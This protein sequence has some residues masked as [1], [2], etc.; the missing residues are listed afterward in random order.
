ML[1]ASNY[2]DYARV[3]EAIAPFQEVAHGRHIMFLHHQGKGTASGGDRVLGST[4]L[5]GAVDALLTMARSDKVFVVDSIQ[6]YGQ[7]LEPT[8]VERDPE[9]GLTHPAGTR[10][11]RGSSRSWASAS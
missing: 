8:R 10:S 1:N 6:R 3:N 9:T 7:D 2:N 5:F 11:G 4:A